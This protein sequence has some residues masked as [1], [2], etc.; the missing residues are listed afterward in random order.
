LAEQSGW[1]VHGAVFPW[2]QDGVR[3][4][5]AGGE[6]DIG[7]GL[8]LQRAGVRLNLQRSLLSILLD[9]TISFNMMYDDYIENLIE[10]PPPPSPKRGLTTLLLSDPKV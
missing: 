3:E 9:P 10:I 8:P 1:E 2:S 4:R 5:E 6:A 7:R